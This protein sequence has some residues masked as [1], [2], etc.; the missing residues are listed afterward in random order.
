MLISKCSEIITN[1]GVCIQ[2]VTKCK[3][4][5][6]SISRFADLK[7]VLIWMKIIFELFFDKNSQYISEGIRLDHK[8]KPSLDSI[9]CRYPFLLWYTCKSAHFKISGLSLFG[10]TTLGSY[11]PTDT[12]TTNQPML[13]GCVY[14]CAKNTAYKNG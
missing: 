4:D 9:V 5:L 7:Q 14:F 11:K 6:S 2:I 3:P 1:Q 12:S 10:K 13:I 8:N